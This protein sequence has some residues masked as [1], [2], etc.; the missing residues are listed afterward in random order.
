MQ[1]GLFFPFLVALAV[2]FLVAGC[3]GKYDDVKKVNKEYMELVQKY[4]DDLDKTESAKAAANAI[5]ISGT[6]TIN[7]AIR[8]NMEPGR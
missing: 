4:V 7:M 8:I 2:L 6:A 1:K 3:E 5:R